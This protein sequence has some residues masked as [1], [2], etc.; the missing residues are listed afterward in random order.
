MALGSAVNLV[1]STGP[2]NVNVPNVVGL[3]QAAA[4]TAITG[5]GLVLGTVTTANSNGVPVGSVISQNPVSGTSVAPGSAVNLVIS[6]G[7]LVVV[8]PNV[9]GLTQNAATGTLTAAGFSIGT[10]STANS[11]TVVAGNVISQNPAGGAS[12]SPGIPVDLVVS[13]G[14]AG[15]VP[16]TLKLTLN[17]QLID[18]GNK[19]TVTWQV[20]DGG[21]NVIALPPSIDFQVLFDAASTTG[22]IPNYNFAN[23]N[24]ISTG[25]DTRGT[26]TLQGT[27]HGTAVTASIQFAVLKN[28]TFVNSINGAT[29]LGNQMLYVSQAAAQ[30]SMNKSLQDLATAVSNNN[31]AAIAA[32]SAAL[33]TAAAKADPDPLSF[34]TPYAPDV[35]FVPT[36]AQLAGQ[37][38]TQTAADIAFGALNSQVRTKIQQIT[39]LLNS[40]SAN[41]GA[42]D[43]ALAQYLSDLQTLANSVQLAANTPGVYGLVANAQAVNDLL[44]RDMP[45][46]LQAIVSRVNG[47][48]HTNGLVSIYGAPLDM[49]H[50]ISSDTTQRLTAVAAPNLLYGKQRPAQFLLGGLI[51][52]CG[53]I[54]TL[55][56]KIY[57]PY[58]FELQ[59]NMIVLGLGHFLQAELPPGP[60]VQGIITGAESLTLNRF[61]LPGSL[62]E[63]SNVTLGAAQ[64]SQV[65]LVGGAQVNA[66]K[67][68]AETVYSLSQV[69][70]MADLNQFYNNMTAAIRGAGNSLNDA[71]QQPDSFDFGGDFCLIPGVISTSC[72]DM[73]YNQGFNFVGQGGPSQLSTVLIIV[74][75]SSVIGPGY[76]VRAAN[77]IGN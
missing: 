69:R 63:I 20:L 14:P 2:A 26:Y 12:V 72:V 46:V 15:A 39:S 8:L 61:H 57:V 44:S 41:Q 50:A 6:V 64:T 51:N 23:V 13:I 17:Q 16:T 22:V 33:T 5:A 42:N 28:D 24:N 49:Y 32:A 56:T 65:Y 48:L 25:A 30:V 71:H 1:V 70:S 67:A 73:S 36:T 66:L 54:G 74:K 19:L 43:A 76:G 3:T 52:N 27:V 18:A 68:L 75:S 77:F 4:T 62:I 59:T 53:I 38:V 34:T 58:M 7:P 29:E 47:E 31:S 11:N 10:V 21:G 35:G 40:P 55:I 9:V 37:G 60:I 45:L